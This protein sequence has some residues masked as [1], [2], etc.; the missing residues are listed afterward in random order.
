MLTERGLN[1]W[2]DQ[3]CLEFGKPWEEG[4]IDGLC[5]SRVFV[6]ILSREAFVSSNQSIL[7]LTKSSPIDNVLLEYRLAGELQKRNLI[8]LV[9][10]VMIGD[11]DETNQTYANYFK[12]GSHPGLKVVSE[13]IVNSIEHRVM[14][15]LDSQSLG[16]P[17]IDKVSIKDIMD[18][19]TKNQGINN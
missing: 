17:L 18:N 14:E 2:L 8:E 11:F 6:P 16:M 19:I 13:V 9:C 12:C 1:V 15:V 3:K 10:P 7:T 5:K 4:F